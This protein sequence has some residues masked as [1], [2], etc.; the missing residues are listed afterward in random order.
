MKVTVVKLFKLQVLNMGLI[1]T[2]YFFIYD[3]L[4]IY[5]HVYLCL[6]IG[7]HIESNGLGAILK[8]YYCKFYY[9]Y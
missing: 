9:Y 5:K 1:P 7:A 6:I 3:I 4:T 2:I 8:Y